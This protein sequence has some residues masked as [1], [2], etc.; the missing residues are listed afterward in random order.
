MSRVLSRK[1]EPDLAVCTA[2][3]SC[4]PVT[5]RQIQPS[6]AFCQLLWCTLHHHQLL[7]GTM[8]ALQSWSRSR[9][10]WRFTRLTPVLPALSLNTYRQ[11]SRCTPP[12]TPVAPMIGA[13]VSGVKCTSPDLAVHRI[14]CI[15]LNPEHYI[16]AGVR[17]VLQESSKRELLLDSCWDLHRDYLLDC[18]L[19]LVYRG[20]SVISVV[21][22]T[23]QLLV[24]FVCL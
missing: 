2:P 18:V 16:I 13:P 21:A 20:R 10:L 17:G 5:L 19:A 6:L 11:L 12:P 9:Q 7:Q 22:C 3:T 15:V 24:R 8:R 14:R 4:A 23:P 1:N